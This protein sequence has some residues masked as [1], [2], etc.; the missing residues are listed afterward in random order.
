MLTAAAIILAAI[1]VVGAALWL[2]EQRYRRRHPEAPAVVEPEQQCCGMHVTCERDSL[3]TSV[4]TEIVYYDDEELDVYKGRQPDSYTP[5]ESEQFREILLTLLPDDIA[6]WARSLGL[7]GIELPADVRE[8]LL[9][10]VSEA[11]AMRATQS[12]A[13]APTA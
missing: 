11:R 4:S 2:V 3:L 12:P 10:I 7:R 8:E 13:D 5:Q 6:P 9:L 1:V